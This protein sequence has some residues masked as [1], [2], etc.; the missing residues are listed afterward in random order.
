M[1]FS[2]VFSNAFGATGLLICCGIGQPI[3][4]EELQGDSATW[5]TTGEALLWGSDGTTD[6]ARAR[7]LFETAAAQGNLKAMRILGEQL[8][9]G[10]VFDQ[11]VD[12]GV[13]LL[14]QAAGAGDP[15]AQRVLGQAFLWGTGVQPDAPKARAFLDQA[16]AGGDHDAM[17]VLGEQLII[18]GALGAD[19]AAGRGLL[20]AAIDAGDVTA[21]V[22]LGTLLLHGTGLAQDKTGA[23]ELFEA[24]ATQGNGEGLLA[25]GE[26]LMWS[27]RDPTRAEAYLNR[28]GDLG[29]NDA[30]A[31]LA[32]GAMYGYLGG[33]NF[34]R[35]KFDPY[36]AKARVA[37]VDKIEILEAERLMWG[38]NMRASGPQT[39]AHLTTAA[40]AGNSAA[41]RFL[42]ELLRD[43]NGLNLHPSPEDARAALDQFAPLLDAADVARYDLTLAAAKARDI[44][45]FARAAE[46]IAARPELMSAAFGKDIYK[47][48]PNVAFYLLQI[49]LQHDGLYHGALNG[50][51]TANTLTAVYQACLQD[52]D[53]ALCADS[54]MRADV[55]GPLLAR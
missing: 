47:A 37:G 26:A 50:F 12:Q 1:R 30:W 17:R 21:Q 39:I 4:A 34:S 6:P 48:S 18:G 52:L 40:Q 49:R 29:A 38:I 51:A 42:I 11:D 31:V 41:A 32:N 25:Y 35:A 14:E 2:S 19:P 53:R 23:L 13:A 7:S 55:I 36:A 10:W 54:V 9:G 8:L 22:T 16:V 43:G 20:R 24:A 27:L 5:V 33:G 3:L 28:A 45:S 44:A 15:V 46:A